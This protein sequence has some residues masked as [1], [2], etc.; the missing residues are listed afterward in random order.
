[1][2]MDD[3]KKRYFRRLE[4]ERSLSAFPRPLLEGLGLDVDKDFVGGSSG[5]DLL[6]YAVT[7]NSY[8]LGGF[9][10]GSIFGSGYALFGWLYPL[11]LALSAPL[12][13][14][15]ADALTSRTRTSGAEGGP[16]GWLPVLSPMAIIGFFAWF[17][18]FTSAARGMES[19]SSLSYYLLR[20]WLE[21]LA[22]YAV[23]Y[24]VSFYA[25]KPF[26]RVR[27]R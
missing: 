18:Y 1:M 5:G 25:V 10:A 6:L 3:T 27:S 11:V 2:G 23:A 17:S 16:G 8:V 14:A 21:V 13:F 4:F 12:L 9:R 22:I 26:A 19:F 20:G 15:L 7:G 24:W